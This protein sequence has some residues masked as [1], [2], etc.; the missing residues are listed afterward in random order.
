MTFSLSSPQPK[1]S[2]ILA[3]R[4]ADSPQLWLSAIVASIAIHLTLGW[5]LRF[6]LLE[7]RSVEQ[8]GQKIIP[9]EMV[10]IASPKPKSPAR[11]RPQPKTLQPKPRQPRTQQPQFERPSRT[12]LFTPNAAPARGKSWRRYRSNGAGNPADGSL[13]A[14]NGNTPLTPADRYERNRHVSRANPGGASSSS[15]PSAQGGSGSENQPWRDRA[16]TH[17]RTA[18]SSPTRQTEPSPTRTAT[19]SSNTNRT[20]PQ[21]SQNPASSNSGS[22]A[23]AQS[24]KSTG[25]SANLMSLNP[26]QRDGLNIS[27]PAQLKRQPPSYVLPSGIELQEEVV[28]KT[29]IE[30]NANGKPI[31]HARLTQVIQG[32]IAPDK[33]GQLAKQIIEQ[34]EFDPT[35]KE[36]Q[37]HLHDYQIEMI[38]RPIFG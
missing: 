35:Y 7:G 36:G 32:N 25:L 38:I 15:N 14:L 24:P 9:I 27:Q 5:M 22:T 34:W 12:P 20:P 23:P 28:L 11:S 37:P 29:I 19:P 30:I 10:A 4:N 33:A 8:S 26:E 18:N 1:V 2:R 13:E 3:Q 16:S 31:V 21:P 6:L 17:Q